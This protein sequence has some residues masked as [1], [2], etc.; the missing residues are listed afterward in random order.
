MISE[1][2][3]KVMHK[4][5]AQS[6]RTK[7]S[8]ILEREAIFTEKNLKDDNLFPHYVIIRRVVKANGNKM[9]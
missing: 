5:N 8:L 6:L 2:Y 7:V 3:E 9:N 4:L 1:S